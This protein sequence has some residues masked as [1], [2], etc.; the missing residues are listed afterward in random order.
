[1]EI[2]VTVGLFRMDGCD[3]SLRYYTLFVVYKELS[4]IYIYIILYILFGFYFGFRIWIGFGSVLD[5][6]LGFDTEYLIS[7]F[8]SKLVRV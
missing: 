2:I 3:V 8:K 5:F 7:K 6:G 1:M 4:S